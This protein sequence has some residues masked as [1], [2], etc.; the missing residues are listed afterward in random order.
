MKKMKRTETIPDE[1]YINLHQ[2][3]NSMKK[4]VSRLNILTNIF[5][6]KYFENVERQIDVARQKRFNGP[7]DNIF[8]SVLHT[9]NSGRNKLKLLDKYL[10]QIF[11]HPS[12]SKKKRSHIEK[13]L[14]GTNQLNMLFEISVTGNIL[15]FLGINKTKLH[16]KT[17]AKRNIDVAAQL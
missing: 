8:L 10:N 4:Q 15:S 9:R 12:I 6:D 7:F 11:E 17:T 14:V 5:S 1:Y 3:L 2:T 13:E 16:L